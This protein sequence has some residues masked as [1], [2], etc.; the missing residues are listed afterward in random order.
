MRRPTRR[1]TGSLSSSS[2]RRI[3]RLIADCETWSLWPAAVNDPVSAMALMISSCRRSTIPSQ[4]ASKDTSRREMGSR[5]TMS[6][7]AVDSR[8][9]R[10]QSSVCS[11]QF[12]TSACDGFLQIVLVE[13]DAGEID[14]EFCAC[15]GRTAKAQEGVNREADAFDAVQLEAVSGQPP[16][17]RRRVRPLFVA[18]LDG[19][20]GQEPGVAAASQPRAG[21][22][23]AGDV[24]L[25][26]VFH[27]D[28]GPF[29]RRGAP[30]AEVKYKLVAV[31]EEPA[32]V[33]WLVVTDGQV[34]VQSA[35]RSRQRLFNR[36]RLD[37]VNDV[38]QLEVRP[39]GLGH[40]QR[41]PGIFRLGADVQ[42]QRPPWGHDLFGCLDPLGGPPQ[43][44]R[45]RP[46]IVIGPVADAKIVRR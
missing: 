46:P 7:S 5:G 42:E 33:D 45:T 8:Q 24:G 22:P 36:D 35:A 10:V 29:E 39:Y 16:R 26:L 23:P 17:K 38:L 32:A 44:L 41:G 6:Q 13:L 1:N 2:R 28:G 21:P 14:P 11:L 37:P 12:M 25:I 40:I 19:V 18:A 31:V 4:D 34:I 3:W 27:A 43:I 9:L 15:D 30:G 20:V